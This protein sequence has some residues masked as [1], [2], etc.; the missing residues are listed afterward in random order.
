MAKSYGHTTAHEERAS[1]FDHDAMVVM[2]EQ[3]VYD[4]DM[5]SSIDQ[6]VKDVLD[7]PWHCATSTSS[8]TAPSS[9]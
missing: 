5:L 9:G 2:A 4:I 8:T 3:G 7:G 1:G 6:T